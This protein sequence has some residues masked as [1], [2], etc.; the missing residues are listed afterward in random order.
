MYNDIMSSG[1][2][3][4]RNLYNTSYGHQLVDVAMGMISTQAGPTATQAAM[5]SFIRAHPQQIS[6]HIATGDPDQ[7]VCDVEP[8]SVPNWSG[9]FLNALNSAKSSGAIKKLIYPPKD[10]AIHIEFVPGGVAQAVQ[11]AE[12]AA[13]EVVEE[14]QSGTD[15][16]SSGGDTEGGSEAPGGVP[17]W[18]WGLGAAGVLW[19]LLRRRKR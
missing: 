12:N 11:A 3:Y 16:I 7:A 2:E 5:A 10:K 17:G 6:H 14:A 1:E 8:S 13:A 9:A 19:Y 18:A 4:E 15:S